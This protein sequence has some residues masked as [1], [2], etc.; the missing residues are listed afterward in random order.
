M[1]K[2]NSFALSASR[3]GA[4]PHVFRAGLIASCAAGL[5]VDAERG[6]RAAQWCSER[7]DGSAPIGHVQSG[8][9]GGGYRGAL[10]GGR[11]RRG[12][13]NPYSN[14]CI[15]WTGRLWVRVC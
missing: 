12:W 9:I 15:A 14:P 8:V 1:L 2:K 7:C 4:R 3:T 10:I 13:V 6:L 11:E 5:L